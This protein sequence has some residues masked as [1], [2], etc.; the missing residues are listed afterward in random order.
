MVDYVN[1]YLGSFGAKPSL[2]WSESGCSLEIASIFS[3]MNIYYS[4]GYRLW[5]FFIR[6][7]KGYNIIK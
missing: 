1:Y 2:I 5:I 7:K 3:I 4:Y 6:I